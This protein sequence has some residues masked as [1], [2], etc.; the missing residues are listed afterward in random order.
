MGRIFPN[1]PRGQPCKDIR[2]KESC[3]PISLMT[4]DAKALNKI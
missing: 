2:K 1:I 4:T 3:R